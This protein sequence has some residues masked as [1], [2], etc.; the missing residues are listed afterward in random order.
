M[1]HDDD[2]GARH[3]LDYCGNLDKSG[4][5]SRT[6]QNPTSAYVFPRCAYFG[7]LSQDITNTTHIHTMVRY[8]LAVDQSY[9]LP[10]PFPMF[11]MYRGADGGWEM[12]R[13]GVTGGQ[14][15]FFFPLYPT[16]IP[17]PPFLLPPSSSSS[18]SSS[19]SSFPIPTHSSLSPPS[20][21]PRSFLLP[22]SLHSSHS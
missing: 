12:G 3:G 6:A 13:G 14:S 8:L 19:P 16:P 1:P 11:H 10:Y 2:D 5:R 18:Q 21:P 20:S 9:V 17:L 15:G 7:H 4:N 22:P